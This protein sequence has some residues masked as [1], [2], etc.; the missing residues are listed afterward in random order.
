MKNESN[1]DVLISDQGSLFLVT[2]MSEAARDWVSENVQLEGW[3][4]MGISF[5]VEWRFAQD[6][7][8]GMQGD[9]LEVA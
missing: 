1:P 5:A 7:I 3:Q 8:S 9:G 2:P 4:W 6:L